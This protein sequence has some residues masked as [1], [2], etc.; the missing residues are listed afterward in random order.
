MLQANAH[1]WPLLITLVDTGMRWSE[2]TALRV[3]EVDL[4][5]LGT[6]K[7]VRA[8]KWVPG[9]GHDDNGV[10]KSK[11]SRRTIIIPWQVKDAI[12]PLLTGKTARDHVFTSVTGK[13]VRHA[14][15]HRLVWKPAIALSGL[16]PAPRIHDLRHTHASW[17][18]E[19]G[20]G[21][22]Q[23]QDQLGHES[24]LTTRKVYAHLQPAMREAV[25]RA[26]EDA[27]SAGRTQRRA[28]ES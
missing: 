27:L 26:A 15:F 7:I 8:T 20:M 1:Y 23:I 16:D 10:P 22:E 5:G 28:I 13:P 2:A 24:I 11:K 4:D 21:L 9:K 18:I 17:L 12:R 14:T 3:G 25:Q 19:F 6:I